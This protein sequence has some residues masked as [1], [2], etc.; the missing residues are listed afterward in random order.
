MRSGEHH[1][2]ARGRSLMA[3][4][5]PGLLLVPCVALAACA[6]AGS[7]WMAEPVSAS[8]A[9]WG[10]RPVPSQVELPP[11]AASSVK[12]LGVEERVIADEP[13]GDDGAGA[14]ANGK[15]LAGRV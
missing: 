2:A 15:A 5:R 8:D 13:L 7:S 9:V 1:R 10:D 6:T 12:R 4:M 3:A 11:P 14:P